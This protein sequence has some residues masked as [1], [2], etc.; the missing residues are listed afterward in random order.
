MVRNVHGSSHSCI[1]DTAF[2]IEVDVAMN[3]VEVKSIRGQSSLLTAGSPL[4]LKRAFN[5]FISHHVL[6]STQL[7]RPDK[8]RPYL[9][10]RKI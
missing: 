1:T 2:R 3:T 7:F 8:N 6:P 4:E 5:P 10:Y 9:I